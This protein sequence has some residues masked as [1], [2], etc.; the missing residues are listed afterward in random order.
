MWTKKR[1]CRPGCLGWL[2]WEFQGSGI[3]SYT[4]LGISESY[5]TSGH[6]LQYNQ[7]LDSLFVW[8]SFY[9]WGSQQDVTITIKASNPWWEK[10]FFCVHA[11]NEQVEVGAVL[12]PYRDGEGKHPVT[13]PFGTQTGRSRNMGY[14]CYNIVIPSKNEGVG[15]E[16]V[17]QA[18]LGGKKTHSMTK[19]VLERKKSLGASGQTSCFYTCDAPSWRR[20]GSWEESAFQDTCHEEEYTYRGPGPYYI[21]IYSYKW[22]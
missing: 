16:V 2:L 5:T 1:H 6:R 7:N 17:N 12:K 19:V 15:L 14:T 9:G 22:S 13:K 20:V 4:H 21:I 10:M 8:C 18:D 3:V 11:S